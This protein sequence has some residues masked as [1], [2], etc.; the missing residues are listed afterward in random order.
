MPKQG[1]MLPY[2]LR[3]GRATDGGACTH[4]LRNELA[5]SERLSQNGLFEGKESLFFQQGDLHDKYRRF[6]RSNPH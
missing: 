1:Q 3:L 5:G 6:F 4:G 2:V